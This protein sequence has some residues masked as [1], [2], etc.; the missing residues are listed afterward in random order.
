MKRISTTLVTSGK[1]EAK[2]NNVPVEIINPPVYHAS[3]VLFDQYRDLAA[4]GRGEYPGL[5]YGA[6]GTPTQHAFEKAM[7]EIEGGYRTRTF[8][9]GINAIINTL[10]AYTRAGDHILVCDNVYGPTRRFCNRVLTRYNVRTEYFPSSSG[11]EEV[12]KYIKPE[13]RLIFLESPGSNTFEIQDIPA[14]TRLARERGVVTVLDNTWATPLYLNPFKL[15]VDVSIQSV[16]KYITG[17]SDVLM[18]TVTTN[19]KSFEAFHDFCSVLESCAS[20]DDCYLALRGLR[21][22]AV[23]LKHHEKSA[24]ELAGWLEKQPLV[25]TVIHPALPS[26]PQ[27]H[28]WKRDFTGS[29]GLFAF[30]MKDERPE[31]EIALFVDSLDLF[32]LGYSWGGFKSLMTVGKYRRTNDSE[33]SGRT[34]FR[35]NVGLEDVEDLKANLA[36]G[37]ELLE[38]GK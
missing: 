18:G 4:A 8:P 1:H 2:Y 19:E 29:S 21:S 13:T 20:Q 34:I 7:A 6:R 16:T 11:R 23:R 30:I 24:L 25:E 17:H 14:I 10:F 28:L 38:A 37:F 36:R 31:E 32:G 27:H 3:T 15:G 5:E 22:L 12:E 26:H 33:Y 9:S 35:V